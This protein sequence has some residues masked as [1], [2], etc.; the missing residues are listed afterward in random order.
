ME[1][2]AA[3]KDLE[4]STAAL[5]MTYENKPPND[6]DEGDDNEENEEGKLC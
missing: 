4:A 3:I 1:L 2:A 5:Q 6:E